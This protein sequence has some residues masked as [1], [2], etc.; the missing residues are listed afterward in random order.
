[1]LMSLS[2]PVCTNRAV[3]ASPAA[4]GAKR[5]STRAGVGLELPSPRSTCLDRQGRKIA[6]RRS[7]AETGTR[8]RQRKRRARRRTRTTLLPPPPPRPA[9]S[10]RLPPLPPPPPPPPPPRPPLLPL[11]PLLPPPPP[12]PPPRQ[13]GA[14]PLFL[15]AWEL[16]HL[17]S[18]RPAATPIRLCA[19]RQRRRWAEC[20]LW[21]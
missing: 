3:T 10:P 19:W 16:S 6:R 13:D 9:Q 20:L 21:L 18:R 1:M 4:T 11:P 12:L 17:R 2:L 8:Q 15:E 7:G 5:V 14:T